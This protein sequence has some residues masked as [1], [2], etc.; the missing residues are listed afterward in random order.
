L[1]GAWE[2]GRVVSFEDQA[3]G[4][5]GLGGPQGYPFIIYPAEAVLS[6]DGWDGPGALYQHFIRYQHQGEAG[7][8]AGSSDTTAQTPPSSRKESLRR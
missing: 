6:L 7:S 5:G 8:A 4:H 1:L 2:A 3:A